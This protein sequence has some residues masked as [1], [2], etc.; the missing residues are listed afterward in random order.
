VAVKIKLMRLGKIREP[1]Y[2]IVVAD[3][4]TRRSGRAIE[5]IGKYHPKREPSFIEVDSERMQYWLGVGAQPTDSVQNILKITGDWQKFKGLPGAEGTLRHPAPPADRL[6]RFQAALTAAGGEPEAEATTPKRKPA[7]RKPK[8]EADKPAAT[9]KQADK[10]KA[11]MGD[12]PE[13]E[14]ADTEAADAE[15]AD[16]EPA[17]PAVSEDVVTPDATADAVAE[18]AAAEPAAEDTAAAKKAPAKK[19]PAKE[20]PAKKKADDAAG[21]DA[22]AEQDATPAEAEAAS[23]A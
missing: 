15:P 7:A 19:A 8:A 9:E 4:R 17:A 23:G 11:E 22:A 18:P 14:A 13:A 12:K 20:A 2:R 21:D 6:A 5:T 16:A 1:Y 10:A 3:A